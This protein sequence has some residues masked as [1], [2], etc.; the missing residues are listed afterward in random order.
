MSMSNKNIFKAKRSRVFPCNV[1]WCICF[2][3]GMMIKTKSQWYLQQSSVRSHAVFIH[4]VEGQCFNWLKTISK[5]KTGPEIRNSNINVNIFVEMTDNNINRNISLNIKHNILDERKGGALFLLTQLS[6]VWGI[7][8]QFKR[9]KTKRPPGAARPS[10]YS[11]FNKIILY[12]PPLY[13]HHHHLHYHHHHHH[14]RHH[15]HHLLFIG[16]ESDH[17][18]C[19][20]LTQNLLK[21]LLLLMLMMWIMLATVCCIFGSWGLVIKLNFCPDFEH[22][23][24]EFEVEVQARFWS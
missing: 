6:P 14:H 13:H 11:P 8:T 12:I 16:P 24:Q 2:S 5:G 22:F 3:V 19:L 21:L 18:Q 23:G 17:W 1:Y 15:H 7:I 10:F 20:S 4:R 9:L